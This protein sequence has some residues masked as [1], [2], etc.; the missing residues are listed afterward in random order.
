MIRDSGKSLCW[1]AIDPGL[2]YIGVDSVDIFARHACE[3]AT[4]IKAAEDACSLK[5]LS[6]QIVT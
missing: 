4:L 3:A 1:P 2:P 6:K 5:L